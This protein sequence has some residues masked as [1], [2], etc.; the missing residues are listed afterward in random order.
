MTQQITADAVRTKFNQIAQRAQ[1]SGMRFFVS[2]EGET[3][4][5][6]SLEDYYANILKRPAALARLQAAAKRR[7][8]ARTPLRKINS[9]IRQVRKSKR[10]SRA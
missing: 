10:T 2:G 3:V 7:G 4:V 1:R 5:L 8:L 9:V 6:L